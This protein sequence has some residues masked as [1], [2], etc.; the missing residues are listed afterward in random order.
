MRSVGIR[1]LKEHTSRIL[2]D[3]YEGRET[4]DVTRHGLVV[5]HLVPAAKDQQRDNRNLDELWIDIDRLAD[6]ISARW[7]E[8]TDAVSAVRNAR[9]EL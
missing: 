8:D 1:D 6:E 7:P 9:R 4:V 3:V 2:K 5:A